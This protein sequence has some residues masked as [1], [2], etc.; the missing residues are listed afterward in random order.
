MPI[1]D[2]LTGTD[3]SR[4]FSP[5]GWQEGLDRLRAAMAAGP[6]AEAA[7]E[8]EPAVFPALASGTCQGCG[9]NLCGTCARIYGMTASH[10]RDDGVC[11][12]G[13][14]ETEGH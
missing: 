8:P 10:L 13:H 14:R 4:T 7:A 2:P 1:I 5:E 6:A 12:W 9:G 11:P 3:L